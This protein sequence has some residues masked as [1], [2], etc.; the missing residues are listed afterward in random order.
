MS[1]QRGHSDIR[2]PARTVDK[3]MLDH[4]HGPARDIIL[5]SDDTS[6]QEQDH[7]EHD[8]NIDEGGVADPQC[9][10]LAY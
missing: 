5:K 2:A 7:D 6:I 9:V 3:E 10:K 1:R 8:E 4:R